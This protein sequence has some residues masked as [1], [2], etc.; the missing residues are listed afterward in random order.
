M[1]RQVTQFISAEIYFRSKNV[2]RRINILFQ[3]FENICGIFTLC[4]DILICRLGESEIAGR[5]DM[6]VLIHG[7]IA[8][9]WQSVLIGTR[10]SIYSWLA[11]VS[12]S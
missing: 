7:D 2:L 4:L 9:V 6:K 8:T 5:S 12:H 10:S 1:N 11:H 3:V